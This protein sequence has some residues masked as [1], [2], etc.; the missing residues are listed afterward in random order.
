MVVGGRCIVSKLR[1]WS[2]AG[3]DNEDVVGD[4][5]EDDI[6]NVNDDIMTR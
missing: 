2:V 4:G 1:W 5:D 3:I 6:Y